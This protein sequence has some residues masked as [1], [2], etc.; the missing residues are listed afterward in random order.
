MTRWQICL[1]NYIGLIL[2][3]VTKVLQIIKRALNL[4][5]AFERFTHVGVNFGSPAAVVP[6]EF[7]NVS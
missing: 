3:I 6:Q 1:T 7:L 5:Q 4:L 2:L